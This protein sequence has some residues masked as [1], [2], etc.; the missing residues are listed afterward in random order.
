MKSSRFLT[1]LILIT[2]LIF[3]NSCK[4]NNSNNTPIP[5]TEKKINIP[6]TP[7]RIYVKERTE[8]NPD[9]E[10]SY[11]I[12][13][14]K[15]KCVNNTKE[16]NVKIEFYENDVKQKGKSEEYNDSKNYNIYIDDK[17]SKGCLILPPNTNLHTFAGEIVVTFTSGNIFLDFYEEKIRQV[18]ISRTS[19]KNGGGSGSGSDFSTVQG[20]YNFTSSGGAEVNGSLTLTNE[21]NWS[22]SGSKTSAPCKNGTYTVS[23]SSITLNYV[24]ASVN[25]SDT[26]TV[27]NSGSSSTWTYTQT[28]SPLFS[29][30][31]GI[32]GNTITFTK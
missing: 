30:L 16:D 12:F 9:V 28:K 8:T 21:G 2:V 5:I 1:P 15:S 10:Y 32:T 29:S 25:S 14:D 31:F 11:E 17:Y 13:Y 23:G 22:Y 19:F 18:T 20:T 6:T 24:A 27:S 7:V 3:N 4:F 26:F